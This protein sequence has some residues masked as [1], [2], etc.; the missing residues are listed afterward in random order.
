MAVSRDTAL[1]IYTVLTRYLTIR[2]I[3]L[4]LDD[5]GEVPGNQ[6]FRETVN[7]LQRIHSRKAAGE[8]LS[9]ENKDRNSRR[10]S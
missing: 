2:Q 10:D 4:V 7:L 3:R 8:G 5:L 6:S 1:S 9:H